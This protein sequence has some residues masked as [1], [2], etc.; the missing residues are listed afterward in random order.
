MISPNKCIV[1][2]QHWNFSHNCLSVT[3]LSFT[4]FILQYTI[5]I[6]QQTSKFYRNTLKI[7]AKMKGHIS[8]LNTIIRCQCCN[9]LLFTLPTCIWK[10]NIVKYTSKRK[11][12]IARF[13]Y[14]SDFFLR[15]STKFKK[16]WSRVDEMDVF[17]R[18]INEKSVSE[19]YCL[20]RIWK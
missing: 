8:K 9:A 12:P 6:H 4:S 17:Y 10:G 19:K 18:L 1:K 14:F 2:Q 3:F 13:I 11:G 7:A 15:K 5:I 16:L 20:N